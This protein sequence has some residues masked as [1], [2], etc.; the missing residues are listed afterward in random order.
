M[1][2]TEARV[3]IFK[4][5]KELQTFPAGTTL[6]QQGDPGDVMYVI[7]DGEVDILLGGKRI[8][9]VGPDGIVGEMALIDDSPRSATAVAKTEVHAVAV[10]ENTFMRYA[11]HTPFFAL[12]V[13][14]VM[15]ER[16]RR[17]M[18]LHSQ[19]A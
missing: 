12:Q 6:M 11:S 14:R 17:M 9:T 8:E 15:N 16:L 18:T 13:M 7:R 1:A 19:Q 5:V 4:F 10:D 3:S 2:E